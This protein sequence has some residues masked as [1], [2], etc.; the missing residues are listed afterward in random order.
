M[1]DDLPLKFERKGDHDLIPVVA[2]DHVTGEIRMFAFANREAVRATLATGRATF[3]S[4]SRN[5][6]W[7]KGKTSQNTLDVVSIAV[8]CD[9][10]ALVY[11]VTPHGPTCHTGAPSCFFRRLAS[12]DGEIEESIEPATLLAR[13]D[14]VLLARKEATSEKSY[15]KSLYDGGAGKIGEK[16]REE[17]D[18]L[19]RAVATEDDGRVVSEAADVLFHIMVALRSRDLGIDAVLRELERRAGTSGHEEKKGRKIK[20][21]V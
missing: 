10:D 1:N 21:V 20:A 5:E 15:A 11:R 14:R 13:L 4:R 6:L 16:L 3:Y 7:E 9:G 18:E 19:A 2:Q 12:P 8:D 17:A